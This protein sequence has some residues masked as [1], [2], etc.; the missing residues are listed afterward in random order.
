MVRKN[1]NIGIVVSQGG[2]ISIPVIKFASQI[3]PET[4]VKELM[5]MRMD[6][7]RK[8]PNLN[9]FSDSTFTI[10][11]M[12]HSKLVRFVPIVHPKQSAVLSVPTVQNK[13]EMGPD[14]QIHEKRVIFMGLSYDHTFLDASLANDYLLEIAEQTKIISD[15]LKGN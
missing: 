14:K 8:K 7:L 3:K 10:S 6:L 9:D 1:I 12:D 15:Q 11:S 4:A 5:R 2:S 13:L